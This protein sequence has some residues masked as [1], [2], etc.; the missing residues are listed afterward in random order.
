MCKDCK[1]LKEEIKFLELLLSEGQ[2]EDWDLDL[3]YEDALTGWNVYTGEYIEPNKPY[4]K[5]L[6]KRYSL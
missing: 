2:S 3:I 1:K 4:A 6:K 5:W